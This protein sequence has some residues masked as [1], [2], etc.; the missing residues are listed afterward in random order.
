MAGRTKEEI[1]E[2]LTEAAQE[3]REVREEGNEGTLEIIHGNIDRML[4]KLHGTGRYAKT[5]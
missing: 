2:R 1:K 5:N 3:A 4:D